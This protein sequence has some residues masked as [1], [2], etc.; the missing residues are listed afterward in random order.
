MPSDLAT[1]PST[2]RPLPGNALEIASLY[3][4]N[5]T[6]GTFGIISF[7]THATTMPFVLGI[8]A[9]RRIKSGLSFRAFSMA[10]SPS[11][12]SPQTSRSCWARYERRILR[13]VSLSS[14]TRIRLDTIDSLRTRNELSCSSARWGGVPRC[15]R[16][17]A[18]A[19]RAHGQA[20]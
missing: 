1:M 9:S 5:R 2:A 12:A 17:S 16:Q 13:T 14:A 3:I 4:V 10:S 18:L 20:Q 6:I 15:L 19:R 11:A 8:A 7:K